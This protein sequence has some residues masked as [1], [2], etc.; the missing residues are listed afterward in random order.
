M[1]LVLNLS[2]MRNSTILKQLTLCLTLLMV[3]QL[4][5]Q[6]KKGTFKDPEDGAIDMSAW[7][8]KKIGF[9][10]VPV[11][12][13]EPAI[14]Y[15]GGLNLMF[16]HSSLEEKQ[17]PPSISG[18]VGG[19]TESDSWFAGGYHLGY[20]KEDAIRYVGA[21][22]KTD[23]NIDYY[24][25]RIQLEDPIIFNLDSWILFQKLTF[26]LKESN[27]FL[28][29]QYVFVSAN[30]SFEF[31]VD[32]PE[33]IGTSFESQL[34]ELG[35]VGTFDTRD[36]VFSPETGWYLES[37]LSYSDEWMGGEALY[38]RFN[39]DV[40]YHHNFSDKWLG[41][42]R[43]VSSH[44]T[45]DTPFWATPFVDL[46]GV[47]AMKIQ[48]NQVNSL[49]GQIDYKINRRWSAD[50]FGGYGLAYKDL[51]SF[52]EGFDIVNFGGGFRYLLARQFGMKAG[53][54]FGWS[55]DSDFAFYFVVGHAW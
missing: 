18:V 23:L 38:G 21:L 30:N 35:F 16:F 13:T 46:R 52:N 5:S 20:W 45:S 34:S 47:P 41:A 29:G 25:S 40:R 36:N 12:I 39:F 55:N 6:E 8:A 19:Y 50:L 43:L 11:L 44:A 10:A 51:S 4:M 14:G 9:L 42:L 3:A 48:S 49:E 15:G 26:R 2:M 17:G 27:F 32:L 33:F 22:F 31:P 7:L 53:M 1:E 37:V 28:G 54:D 24:S